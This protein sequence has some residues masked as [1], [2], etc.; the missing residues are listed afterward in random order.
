MT[1]VHATCVAIDGKGVLLRGASASGKS[2]LALRLIDSGARLVADDLV[3]LRA[4]EEGRQVIASLPD[5]VPHL[6]GV[7]EVRGLGLLNMPCKDEAPL[8]LSVDLEA[9]QERLPE[10]RTVTLVGVDIDTLSLNAFEAS[11]P[12]KIRAALN[13]TRAV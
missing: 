5:G 12:A 8:R 13:C 10:R 9:H 1:T 7:L 3:A 11:A 6:R 2:D 4:S